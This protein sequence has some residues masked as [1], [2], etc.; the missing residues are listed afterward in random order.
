[1]P[2][3]PCSS[4]SFYGYL[5]L[6][7]RHF[8][9]TENN[10]ALTHCTKFP[11]GEAM[12][13]YRVTN[14][15]IFEGILTGMAHRNSYI[16]VKVTLTLVRLRKATGLEPRAVC[17][18]L[19]SSNYLSPAGLLRVSSPALEN[20]ASV[21][22]PWNM[23][24]CLPPES[25]GPSGE[26]GSIQHLSLMYVSAHTSVRVYGGQRLMLGTFLNH[27]LPHILRPCFAVNLELTVFLYDWQVSSRD[28]PVSPPQP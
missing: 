21:Y 24:L 23:T 9:G 8:L 6:G 20:P 22:R 11:L 10:T 4:P 3:F 1:M 19:I 15:S 5:H 28:L 25:N 12:Y 7:E 16:T 13:F 17:R 27:G 18:H 26:K 2:E 14:R